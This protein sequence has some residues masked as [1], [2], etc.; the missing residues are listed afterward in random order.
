MII[1]CR[2]PVDRDKP[3]IYIRVMD[4]N[5]KTRLAELELQKLEQKVEELVRHCQRLAEE[6]RSLRTQHEHLVSE[7]TTLIEK[8]E[9]AKSRVEAMITRLRSMESGS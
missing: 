6:N 5:P 1:A 9:Q 3:S 2:Y 7:R 8:T 4:D